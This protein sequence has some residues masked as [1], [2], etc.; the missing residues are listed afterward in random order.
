MPRTTVQEQPKALPNS[1]HFQRF[2]SL[3]GSVWGPP[4]TAQ[5]VGFLAG[6]G[7]LVWMGQ[8]DRNPQEWVVYVRT[9]RGQVEV[10]FPAYRGNGW[11]H[12]SSEVEVL[13]GR[14]FDEIRA[15]IDA[16]SAGARPEVVTLDPDF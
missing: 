2:I 11:L 10:K 5:I 7:E 12:V 14:C 4:T 15:I 13:S 8:D 3:P 9:D 6:L 16:V 1:V